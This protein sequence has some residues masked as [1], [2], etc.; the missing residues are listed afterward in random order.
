M[1]VPTLS[2]ETEI[3]LVAVAL[4]HGARIVAR[5]YHLSS[6]DCAPLDHAL[7]G[8]VDLGYVAAYALL[9]VAYAGTASEAED[10][11]CHAVGA[12]AA[13]AGIAAGALAHPCGM[14]P[15]QML[16]AAWEFETR[17]G[18]RPTAAAK[19]GP[20][21]IVLQADPADDDETGITL[22]GLDGLWTLSAWTPRVSAG[23]SVRRCV[24]PPAHRELQRPGS[25]AFVRRTPLARHRSYQG[26]ARQSAGRAR[27]GR[28]A[29]P[30]RQPHP[31]LHRRDPP[32]LHHLLLP[33]PRCPWPRP[34]SQARP[35]RRR[36]PRPSPPPRRAVEGRNQ[37]RRGS[38]RRRLQK[39]GGAHRPDLRRR[40]LHAPRPRNSAQPRHRRRVLPPH[41]RRPW[42]QDPRRGQPRRWCVLSTESPT[43]TPPRP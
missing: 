23:T 14:T 43:A 30:V 15:P 32:Q 26:A 7:L 42:T 28:Q 41:H 34:R 22:P 6:S 16:I 10:D 31:R 20:L 37:P 9:P 24:G 18:P 19:A 36:H 17:R 33:L 4:S 29:A 13:D 35:P 21:D 25:V 5:H 1:S 8:L 40:A 3:V 11:L 12:V 2:D 27:R 39:E 38:R